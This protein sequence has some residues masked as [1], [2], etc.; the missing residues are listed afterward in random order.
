MAASILGKAFWSCDGG[1]WPSGSLLVVF[2]L[3]VVVV[4]VLAVVA[5]VVAAVV[6]FVVMC[7]LIQGQGAL[8][9]D[10]EA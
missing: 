3:L 5:V 8:F 1:L 4:V 9:W 10:H 2:R 7:F 6:L